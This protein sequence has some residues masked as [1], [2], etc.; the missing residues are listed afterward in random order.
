VDV[1]RPYGEKG[2]VEI[3]RSAEEIVAK[4]ESILSRPRDAWL[5]KVDRHLASG[6]WDTT[7]AAMHKLMQEK[8]DGIGI[9][10]PATL[11]IY[12]TTPAE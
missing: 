12:A 5:A 11:P 6:S 8:L 7:W 10:R 1:I 4:A 2:L 3:A 9:D